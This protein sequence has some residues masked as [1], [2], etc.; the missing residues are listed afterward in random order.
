MRNQRKR[1]LC[2]SL[3]FLRPQFLN[4]VWCHMVQ[5]VHT[6]HHLS[7][8]S[9]HEIR[10]NLLPWAPIEACYP[11]YK[12]SQDLRRSWYP[13]GVAVIDVDLHPRCLQSQLALGNDEKSRL[14]NVE[15]RVYHQSDNYLGHK[16]G[17]ALIRHESKFDWMN[18]NRMVICMAHK[19]N[20]LVAC[21]VLVI[22]VAMVVAPA[23]YRTPQ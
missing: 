23:T 11:S 8:H 18:Y 2:L 14:G 19:M 10:T 16:E 5:R 15:R 4:P 1:S 21:L 6:G 20:V 12:A 3:S 17:I 22:D 13:C 9:E 7:F